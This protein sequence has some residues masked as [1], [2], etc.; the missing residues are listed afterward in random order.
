[1]LTADRYDR[2]SPTARAIVETDRK[3][4][5]VLDAVVVPIHVVKPGGTLCQ[6]LRDRRVLTTRAAAI[7]GKPLRSDGTGP[8]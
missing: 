4:A 3:I 8:A 5:V 2:L 6:L 7:W 1:M